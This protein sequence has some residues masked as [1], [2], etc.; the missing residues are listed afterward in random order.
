MPSKSYATAKMV[1]VLDGVE[2]AL[3][4]LLGEEGDG[5]VLPTGS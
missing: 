1:L 3:H 2:Q 5:A 4:F